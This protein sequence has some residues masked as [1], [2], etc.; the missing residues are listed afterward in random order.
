MSVAKA[1]TKK[2]EKA[3]ARA[4]RGLSEAEKMQ[5]TVD[6]LNE[7]A[8]PYHIKELIKHLPKAKGI[9]FQSVEDVVKMLVADGLV[10]ND[11]V[12]IT[13]LYWSFAATA[14]K[15]KRGLVDR[16]GE[17]VESLKR[18]RVELGGQLAVARA[19]KADTAEREALQARLQQLREANA[20]ADAEL[21]SMRETDP[22]LI[23]ELARGA[24]EALQAANRW[25]D[26]IY[27]LQQF[28]QTRKGIAQ[29]EFLR[30][31]GLPAD[32]GF[33]GSK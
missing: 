3:A 15:A 5:R 8:E 28:A 23:G 29:R 12:G 30:N 6:Y 11:K 20:R 19:G 22:E 4:K 18:R 13:S 17:E 14:T 25:T 27:S 33:L 31:F 26:A 2:A 24:R 9:T 7:H 32:F 16:L 1:P 21:L 10:Q